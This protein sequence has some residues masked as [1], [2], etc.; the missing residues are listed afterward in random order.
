[1]ALSW[2]MRSVLR[3]AATAATGLL[4]LAAW[5]AAPATAAKPGATLSVWDAQSYE[6]T[7]FCTGS[8]TYQCNVIG[9]TSLVITIQVTNRPK[10]LAPI[11]V[12]YQVQNV[13][14][15]AGQDYQGATSGTVTIPTNAAQA[16]VVLPIVNDGVPESTETLIVRLTSATVPASLT[17]IGEGTIFDGSQIPPDC[18]LA[19]VENDRAKS[20]TC[21]ARPTAEGWRLNMLCVGAV[22]EIIAVAMGNTVNGDGTSTARCEIGLALNTAFAS[23]P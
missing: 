8:P 3:V 11:T 1:M 18:S 5:S 13:T 23:V 14:T 16:N 2:V 12:G 7:K 17:D 9:G 22:G 19:W 15:T 20:L 10:P 21:T 6:Y 4:L